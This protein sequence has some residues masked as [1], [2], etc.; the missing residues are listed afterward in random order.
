M[1]EYFNPIITII[2]NKNKDAR[3]SLYEFINYFYHIDFSETDNEN[4]LIAMIDKSL[5]I[6]IGA[7]VIKKYKKDN[8]LIHHIDYLCVDPKYYRK[9]IGTEIM[10]YI[11]NKFDIPITLN[12]LIGDIHLLKFYQSVCDNKKLKLTVT[13]TDKNNNAVHLLIN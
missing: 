9:K 3:E 10:N 5:N 6:I 13:E 2:D 7:G 12:I 11:I 4:I 8:I 1:T